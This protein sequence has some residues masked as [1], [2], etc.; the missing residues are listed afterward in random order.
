MSTNPR[1]NIQ[2]KAK[3]NSRMVKNA[4]AKLFK[5]S[6][7]ESENEEIRNFAKGVKFKS[8]SGMGNY[9]SKL[10]SIREKISEKA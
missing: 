9:F 5:V 7:D 4:N 1:K 3:I 2:R 10:K 8:V 6:K